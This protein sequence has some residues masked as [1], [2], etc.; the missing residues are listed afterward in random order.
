MEIVYIIGAFILLTALI[1]GSLSYRYQ[2]SASA[3]SRIR[4]FVTAMSTTERNAGHSGTAALCRPFAGM[5]CPRCSKLMTPKSSKAFV[6]EPCREIVILFTVV[7][8]FKPP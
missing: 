8:K 3:R 5:T 4:S 1:Y 7:S 6:C 2:N